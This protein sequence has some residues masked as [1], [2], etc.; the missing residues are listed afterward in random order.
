MKLLKMLEAGAGLDAAA[1]TGGR[2]LGRESLEGKKRTHNEDECGCEEDEQCKVCRKKKKARARKQA[3]DET[4]LHSVTLKAIGAGARMMAGAGGEVGRGDGAT[5]S[6]PGAAHRAAI[7]GLTTMDR[8]ELRAGLSVIGVTATE[9]AA[10]KGPEWEAL[11][12]AFASGTPPSVM[13]EVLSDDDV[14]DAENDPEAFQAAVAKALA[15]NAKAND[16]DTDDEDDGEDDGEDKSDLAKMLKQAEKDLDVGSADGGEDDEDDEDDEGDDDDDDEEGEEGEED[17]EDEKKSLSELL[18]QDDPELG[19]ALMLEDVTKGML[20]AFE[21]KQTALVDAFADLVQKSER[22]TAKQMRALGEALEQMGRQPAG[23]ARPYSVAGSP[24]DG[25][26]DVSIG[27]VN[28]TVI[29]CQRKGLLTQDDAVTLLG[30]VKYGGS[31]WAA[32]R[33]KYDAAVAQLEKL[34]DTAV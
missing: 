20:V 8:D 19:E 2:A 17:E 14:Y 6:Q 18:L 9:M 29:E 30:A 32:Q 16:E 11:E 31:A 15:K 5:R 33:A 3:E 27:G 34:A 22:R 28:D 12:K 25:E 1:F 10:I 21:R 13:L 23:R 24:F 7:G 4:G 26:E